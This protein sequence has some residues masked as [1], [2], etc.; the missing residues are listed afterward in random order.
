VKKGEKGDRSNVPFYSRQAGRRT[1]SGRAWWQAKDW[2]WS[3]VAAHLEG[4]N[5][6]L[7]TARPVLDRAGGES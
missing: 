5:D 6:G 7:V 2:P 1:R 3:S 4:K